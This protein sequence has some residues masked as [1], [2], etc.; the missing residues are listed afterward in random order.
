M[1]EKFRFTKER[2]D[3]LAIPD[4]DR[5]THTDTLEPTLRLRVGKTGIKSFMVFRKIKGKP[6]TVTLGRYPAMTIDQARNEARKQVSSMVEGIDPNKAKKAERVK[7][8]TLDQCLADYLVARAG[9]AESTVEG[10]QRMLKNHLLDWKDKPLKLI[11]R[12]MVAVRHKRI[13]DGG[14]GVAAN[15]VMRLVRA[16][17][18][19]AKEQ[20][21]D[22]H[23]KPAARQIYHTP[24]S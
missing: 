1:G 20:Y 14:E 8:V 2:L 19:F 6:I 21:N 24:K 18:N 10:Y 3:N 22:E 17:F 4:D 16:L 5:E 13:V 7:G 11:D 12:D 23:G 9:L 15:N